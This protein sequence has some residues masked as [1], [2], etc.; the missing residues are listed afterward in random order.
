MLR[1]VVGPSEQTDAAVGGEGR[2]GPDHVRRCRPQQGSWVFYK[3]SNGAWSL[4]R[5]RFLGERLDWMSSV[6]PGGTSENHLE[7]QSWDAVV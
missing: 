5:K 1:N 7:I 2:Q 3:M 4:A 6:N